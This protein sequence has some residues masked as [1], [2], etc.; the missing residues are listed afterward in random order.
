[1]GLW[2][3]GLVFFI[4]LLAAAALVLLAWLVRALWARLTGQPVQPW[5]FRLD[6]QAAW[7]RFRRPADGFEQRRP[8]RDDAADARRRDADVTDVEPKRVDPP[9]R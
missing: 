8:G 3:A 6:R 9:G 5:T 1:M 2:L 4:S 7:Q